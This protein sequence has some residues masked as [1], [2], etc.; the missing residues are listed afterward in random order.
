MRLEFTR[1][2]EDEADTIFTFQPADGGEATDVTWEMTGKQNLMGK[3]MCLFMDMDAMVGG[4]FEEGLAN[5]KDV[6]EKAEAK[7]PAPAID[8]PATEE[9]TSTS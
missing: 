9:P 5:L 2:M 7:T 6:S 8:E 3:V 4:S 1:P